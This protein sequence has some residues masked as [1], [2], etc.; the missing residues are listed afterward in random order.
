M[1]CPREMAA[2]ALYT[3]HYLDHALEAFDR[4]VDT[5]FR[6]ARTSF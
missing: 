6:F 5:A 3:G 1:T 2:K 4:L